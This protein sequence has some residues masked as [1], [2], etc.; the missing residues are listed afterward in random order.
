MLVGDSYVF[1]LRSGTR[2]ELRGEQLAAVCNSGDVPHGLERRYLKTVLADCGVVGVSRPPCRVTW[3]DVRLPCGGRDAAVRFTGQ[4]ESGRRT[5][6][7]AAGVLVELRY[8]EAF[9]VAVSPADHV[10]VFVRRY[11]DCLAHIHPAV[12]RPILEDRRM[13]GVVRI[14]KDE[15]AFGQYLFFGRNNSL[16]QSTC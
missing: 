2:S 11:G 12:G 13:C 5:E 7:E 4:D 15:R 6:P 1:P 3:K 8:A 16:V 9:L 14:G 10:E